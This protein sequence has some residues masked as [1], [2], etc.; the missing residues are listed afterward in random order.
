MTATAQDPGLRQ[1]I[2]LAGVSLMRSAETVQEIPQRA[3]TTERMADTFTVIDRPYLF[4]GAP[5]AVTKYTWQLSFPRVGETDYRAFARAEASPGFIDFCLWKPLS[6]IFSGDGSTV[7]FQLLR[8]NALTQC[9]VLPVNAATI[10]AVKTYIGGTVV[11][12]PTFGSP[13]SRGVTPI[14]FGS[15]PAAGSSNIEVH[16]VPLYY[17]YIDSLSREFPVDHRETRKLTL[18]EI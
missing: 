14:T 9:A 2:Y 7:T 1:T 6:E 18:I 4:P 17:T 8:R 13:D 15:A 10:Y 11:A 3:Q 5:D 16:Y 12:N